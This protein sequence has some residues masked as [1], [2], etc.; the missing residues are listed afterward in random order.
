MR[1]TNAD[2]VPEFVDHKISDLKDL[3]AQLIERQMRL[4]SAYPANVSTVH[5][6]DNG[7]ISKLG[8]SMPEVIK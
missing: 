1:R 5:V 3:H 7:Y 6:E 2:L 8:V 4:R